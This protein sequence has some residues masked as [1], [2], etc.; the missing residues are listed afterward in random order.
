[1]SIEECLEFCIEHSLTINQFIFLYTELFPLQ[2]LY[3]K[4]AEKNGYKIDDI[5]RTLSKELLKDL[6][7]R[8]FLIKKEDEYLFTEK[9]SVLYCDY[10]TLGNEIFSMYPAFAINSR[11]QRMPL[12][13]VDKYV[14][15]KAYFNLIKGSKKEHDQILLDL[16]YAVEND[17]IN[18]KIDKFILGEMWLDFRLMRLGKDVKLVNK[19]FKDEDF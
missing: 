15:C 17:Y 5:Y 6:M 11:N 1:M 9:F 12:K 4:Y 2:D 13:G 19:E 8:E 16:E 18:F 10:K 14:V 7:D 3:E